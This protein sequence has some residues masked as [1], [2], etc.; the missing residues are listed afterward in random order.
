MRIFASLLNWI[1]L[2]KSQKEIYPIN[3]RHIVYDSYE[4]VVSLNEDDDS[5]FGNYSHYLGV[6][7]DG[8]G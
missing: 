4:G 8:S 1:K 3:V 6:K 2:I 5:D 7:T